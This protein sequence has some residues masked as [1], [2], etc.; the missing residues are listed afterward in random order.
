[1][2]TTAECNAIIDAI[3]YFKGEATAREISE[4]TLIKCIDVTRYIRAL[5]KF[6]KI[7][8]K[9]TTSTGHGMVY[10]LY[11]TKKGLE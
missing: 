2:P 10:E 9:R 7:Q 11:E 4:H 6:R 5:R 1:M 3:K 8:I